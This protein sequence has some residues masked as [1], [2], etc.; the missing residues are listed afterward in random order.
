MRSAAGD[1]R[2]WVRELRSLIVTI[3]PP[4]L[5]AQG[6]RSTLTDLA[7]TLEARG[8]AVT[9]TADEV[10]PVD[11]TSEV[12]AYR[13]AQEG[14][15]NVVR[16]A[17]ATQVLIA[18]ARDGQG[19][20]RLTVRDD[21]RGLDER[22]EAAR[23]RGSVGLDLLGQLVAAHGGRLTVGNAPAGGVELV[24]VLPGAVP[25]TPPPGGGPGTPLR[26]LGAVASTGAGGPG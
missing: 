19:A 7:A 13:A 14:V 16:H 3:V 4:A 1:L 10:G 26:E 25:A 17:E 5:H 8:I 2:R 6:L 9:V 21:G 11:E 23:R 24:V 22:Y 12:L 20:L 18:V 15:R